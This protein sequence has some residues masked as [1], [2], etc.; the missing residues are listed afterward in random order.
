MSDV[1]IG[2]ITVKQVIEDPREFFAPDRFFP[3]STPETIAAERDWMTPRYYDEPTGSLVLS[4]KSYVFRSNGRA[5]LVDTCVGNHKE[6]RRHESWNHG[7]WPWLENLEAAGYLPEDIDVVMCTHLHADHAGWNTRLEN[8]RWVPTFPNAEYLVA[9][10]ELDAL[11]Y[12]REHGH[13]QYRHLYEDS[14]LPVIQSGQVVMV[15]PDHTLDSAV[16]LEPSPGHTA[17][18]VSVRIASGGEQGV[19]TGDMIHHPIQA[20][21]PDWNSLVCE[22]PA[23]AIATRRAFLERSAD[24]GTWV[25]PAH[26]DPCRAE[27]DGEAFRFVF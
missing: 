26:F 12:K 23:Q 24:E 18:H 19:A 20:M 15:Q 5:V 6:G 7:E 21:H 22:D 13:A 2:D 16:R 11:E 8:G 17:G 3:D 10:P 4:I 27:R 25:L 14:V 1:Q 9:R